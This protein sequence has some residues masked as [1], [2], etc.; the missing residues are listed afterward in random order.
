MSRTNYKQEG[1]QIGE[2][3]KR[4]VKY[5]IE[6]LAVALAAYYIPRG[7]RLSFEEVSMIAITAAA[8]FAILDMYTPSIGSAA[9]TGAG[10][11]IGANIAGFPAGP[12]MGAGVMGV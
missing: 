3:I 12:G 2:V 8:T 4:A 5:L 9:R 6:G 11:G 10:F 7:R 1:F